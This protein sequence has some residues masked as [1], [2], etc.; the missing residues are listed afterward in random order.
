MFENEPE[1]LALL[2]EDLTQRISRIKALPNEK[3]VYYFR[4][5]SDARVIRNVPSLPLFEA[6]LRARHLPDGQQH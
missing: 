3:L 5:L 4:L 6:E 1:L 2:A